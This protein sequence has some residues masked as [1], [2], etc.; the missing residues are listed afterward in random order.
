MK[1]KSRQCQFCKEL[2]EPHGTKQHWCS[3][4]CSFWDKVEIG[5][6]SKCWIWP[7][8]KITAGYGEFIFSA[9]HFYTHRFMWQEIHGKIPDD[10]C[11]L[12]KCDNPSCIN[13][14]HLFL[15]TKLD[16]TRD[17][18][19]KDRNPKGEDYNHAKLTNN[20]VIEIRQL[21]SKGIYQKDIASIYN[22]SQDTISA[23]KL[24]Q[25]WSHI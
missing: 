12:H 14:A 5:S 8:G 3:P 16:N 21:L 9:M 7:Y 17:M 23:I 18:I 4:K 10:M 24:G 6:P 22:V 11:I 20:H 15:G 25:T 19:S 2:F 13:P 1:Y